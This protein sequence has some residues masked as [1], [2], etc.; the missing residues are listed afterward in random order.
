MK[1]Y[2]KVEFKNSMNAAGIA[3]AYY[4]EA[5]D[6][7]TLLIEGRKAEIEVVSKRPEKIIEA[8]NYCKKQEIRIIA[9][10]GDTILFD[11]LPVLKQDSNSKTEPEIDKKIDLTETESEIVE[12]VNSAEAESGNVEKA[13][14]TKAKSVE[15]ADLVETEP[16]VGV[17]IKNEVP[18]LAEL[19]EKSDSFQKFIISIAFWLDLD[20]KRID[21]FEEIV[22]KAVGMEEIIF[23]KI[24]GKITWNRNVCAKAIKEKLGNSWTLLNFLKAVVEYKNYFNEEVLEE[25][26]SNSNEEEENTRI[27][28]NCM[29]EIPE[30]EKVL[31]S[32]DKT[33]PVEE[34][35]KYVLTAMGFDKTS[36]HD[37]KIILLAVNTA[38][39]TK[40][41]TIDKISAKF[42][43]IGMITVEMT[44]SKFI[45]EYV[46]QYD[47]DKMVKT[48]DFLTE[49][50]AIIM[51]EEEIVE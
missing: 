51:N 38:I 34:R 13:N 6:E 30:F 29:P 21:Y 35:V 42:I 3:R 15:E 16:K 28:M 37:K 33:Q 17:K 1:L 11:L 31:G 7:S 25:V 32:V 36:D 50:Q 2:A 39:T 22:K 40:N 24:E 14:S 9:E 5:N 10:E 44:L 41:M 26:S 20:A 8:I 12:E 19:A 47:K 43:N 4:K 23:S 45:N 49:L 46:Q 18:E 27:K 48:M